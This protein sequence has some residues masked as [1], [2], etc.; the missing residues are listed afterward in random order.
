MQLVVYAETNAEHQSQSDG[1]CTAIIGLIYRV[2][3]KKR[4][5]LCVTITARILYGEKFPFAHL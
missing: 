5:V 3:L 2:A 1:F 4:P